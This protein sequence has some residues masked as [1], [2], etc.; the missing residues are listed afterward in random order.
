MTVV[1]HAGHWLN[2]VIYVAPVLLVC[3]ALGVGRLRDRRAGITPEQ[4]DAM[5]QAS[6]DGGMDGRA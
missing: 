1:A 6:L 3:I 2:N 4:R 5:D